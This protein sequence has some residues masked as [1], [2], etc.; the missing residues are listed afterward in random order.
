VSSIIQ[1]TLEQIL[2]ECLPT[3]L[4]E[5]ISSTY[6]N[7]VFS[8]E[9]VLNIEDFVQQN[10]LRPTRLIRAG[11][12]RK[13]EWNYNWDGPGIDLHLEFGPIPFYFKTS[14]HLRTGKSVYRDKTGYLEFHALMA[15]Q[16]AIFRL[17]QPILGAEA[18]CEYGCGTGSNLRN[19][20]RLFKNISFYGADWASSANRYANERYINNFKAFYTVDFFDP[21]TYTGP[22]ELFIAFT[23]AALEQSGQEFGPFIDYLITNK[24]C[25]GGIHIEPIA[26]LLNPFDSL[27]RQSIHYTSSRNYLSG[28]PKKIL[29]KVDLEIFMTNYGLGSRYL[30]GY[31]LLVWKKKHG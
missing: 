9:P 4:L 30:S 19:L 17:Y 25:V 11:K 21:N 7:S 1:L 14:T 8:V 15:Y 10:Y 6:L 28:L 23:N 20:S 5:N 31:Q 18:L 12:D 24:N 16:S 13:D 3:N 2:E 26:E 29:N 22:P 27:D